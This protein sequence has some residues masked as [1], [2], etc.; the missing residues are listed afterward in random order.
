MFFITQSYSRQKAFIAAQAPLPSTK[1]D[2]WTVIN[3][4]RIRTVVMLCGVTEKIDVR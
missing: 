1:E 2:F 4:L 3:Q